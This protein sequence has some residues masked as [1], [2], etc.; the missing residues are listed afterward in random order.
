M[1]FF[2]YLDK[3]LIY[4][5]KTWY[6]YKDGDKSIPLGNNEARSKEK[7]SSYL[8]GKSTAEL[9]VT[10][11]PIGQVE[12]A[13]LGTQEEPK[14]TSISE[15]EFDYE[16]LLSHV[17]DIDPN[18]K[19][20]TDL[21]IFID[22]VDSRLKE[23]PV[24][25]SFPLSFYWMRKDKNVSNGANLISNN[26]YTVVSKSWKQLKKANGEYRIRVNKDDSP[27]ED[28]F[29]VGELVLCVCKK[30]Q[31]EQKKKQQ[32]A[33]TLIVSAYHQQTRNEKA[34]QIA[35]LTDTGTAMR[36]LDSENS[37]G[38]QMQVQS[39]TKNNGIDA[40]QAMQMINNA[41]GDE[42]LDIAKML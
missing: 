15:D 1:D 37:T 5:D 7:L 12:T 25:K 10:A 6:Y 16:G 21:D 34:K 4:R 9:S 30:E 19:K 2:E 39:L 35:Q 42:A 20:G 23:H 13:T 32:D 28:Y 18:M 33:K 3:G 40:V 38:R 36:V 8:A 26:Q 27:R 24:V 11:K 41:T 29:S 14:A 31:Y 17:M 22:G